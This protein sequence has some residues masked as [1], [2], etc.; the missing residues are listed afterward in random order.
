MK[1]LARRP[2]RLAAAFA[3]ALIAVGVA[4][5][6]GSATATLPNPCT[7]LTKVHPEHA[8]ARKGKHLGVKRRKLA[9]YGAGKQASS[10]CSETVGTMP[11]SLS[12]SLAAPGGF[13][14]VSVT[15]TTHPAGLGSG[16]MLVVGKS[17]TGGPVDFISFHTATIYA[18]L[19][20]NGATPS[21]LTTLARQV[22]K[23]LP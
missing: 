4:A 15:S 13:G 20:A 2:Q 17:P 7:L 22:Y 5:A 16:D 14:G 19:S 23:L 12:L 6:T 1:A 3:V 18:S 10:I 21:S 9:R 8:L 11:V